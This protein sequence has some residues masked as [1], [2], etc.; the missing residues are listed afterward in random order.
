M[1]HEERN[2]VTEIIANA[3]IIALFLWFLMTGHAAGRFDG[4]DGVQAWASLVLRL[5]G[6][7]I[8]LGIVLAI[9]M[10]IFWHV[11][12]GEKPDLTRDE[13][14][15]AISGLGWKWTTLGSAAGFV[16]GIVALAMG[17]SVIT[18]LNLM[19]AGCALGD[20]GGNLAKLHAYRRGL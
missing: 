8:A 1:S 19:L 2:V 6:A 18:G 20:T 12:T 9:A 13:R 3:M 14:D 7:S 5:I 4:A 11:L 17:G 10:G 16:G 15:R